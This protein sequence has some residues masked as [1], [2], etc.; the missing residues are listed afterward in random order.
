MQLFKLFN[1]Q[2]EAAWFYRQIIRL[3]D[4]AEPDPSLSLRR[5]LFTHFA[6]E[7]KVAKRRSFKA[8]S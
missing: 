2:G 8:A 6:T 3:A 7:L 1:V 4:G 5:A